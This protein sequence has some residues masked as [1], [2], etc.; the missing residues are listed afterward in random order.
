MDECW[1]K[2]RTKTTSH[3]RQPAKATKRDIDFAGGTV[4]QAALSPE[5]IY[6]KIAPSVLTLHDVLFDS[7]QATLKPGAR[8][9][10][11]I[12]ASLRASRSQAAFG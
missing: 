11:R 9:I 4:V 8:A 3:N 2:A 10:S 1:Q 5:E 12:T 6:E 7:G